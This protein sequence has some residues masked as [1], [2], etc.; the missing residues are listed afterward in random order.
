MN[1]NRALTVLLCMLAF[2]L[3]GCGKSSSNNS[4]LRIV[5]VIPDAPAVS[6]Q[7]G[8]NP[9]LITGLLFQQLTQYLNAPG[10][11]QDFMVS[12][13]GGHSFAINETLNLGS[14]NFTYIVYG[15]VVSATGL[16]ISENNLPSL[17]S[18][19]FNF[20]VINVAAGIGPV[21]IYLTPLG[22]D[23]NTTSPTIADVGL[24]AVSAFIAINIGYVG[25]PRDRD[26]HEERH[27]RHRAS[28]FC[29]RGFV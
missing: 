24:G 6:V 2:A 7:L 19:Q 11:S 21:D 20:R 16:L 10:G 3:A 23:L 22:T 14:G 5:N 28:G 13:N 9:P 27:L 25:S 15:P 1:S 17:N 12:A 29:Q 8:T 4:M 18:G 26:R